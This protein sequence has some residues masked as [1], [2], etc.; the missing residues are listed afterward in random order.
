MTG[1]VDVAEWQIL[2]GGEI[3]LEDAVEAVDAHIV[4]GLLSVA[5]TDGPPRV[6]LSGIRGG[7]VIINQT[8]GVVTIRHPAVGVHTGIGAASGPGGGLAG[9]VDSVIGGLFGAIGGRY[10]EVAVLLPAPARAST[11]T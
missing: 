5:V 7:P 11:R 10:A 9:L 8:G 4:G 3:E 6:V 1:E 2:D